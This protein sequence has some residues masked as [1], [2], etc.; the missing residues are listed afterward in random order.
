MVTSLLFCPGQL[1]VKLKLN[2]VVQAVVEL[3]GL[4]VTLLSRSADDHMSLNP[5]ID[6]GV[7]VFLE[8]CHLFFVPEVIH[9]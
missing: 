9:S 7:G 1:A 8:S 6:A 4:F 2:E 3:D 5:E